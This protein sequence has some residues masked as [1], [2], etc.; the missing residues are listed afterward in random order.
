V[1]VVPFAPHSIALKRLMNITGNENR[2]V[3]RQDDLSAARLLREGNE[4]STREHCQ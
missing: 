1:A 3:E 4:T 2:E